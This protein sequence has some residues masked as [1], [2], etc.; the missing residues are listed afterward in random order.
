MQTPYSVVKVLVVPFKNFSYGLNVT[1][2]LRGRGIAAIAD[3]EGRGVSKNL[4]FANRQKIPFIVFCGEKEQDEGKVKLRDMLSG[5]EE[6][7][8]LPSALAKLA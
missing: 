7:L 3:L 1:Q 6:L 8:S 4:D 2:E 5:K